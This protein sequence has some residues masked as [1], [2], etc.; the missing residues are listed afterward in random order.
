MNTSFGKL[1]GHSNIQ[2]YAKNE[3]IWGNY[4]LKL[5]IS[6]AIWLESHEPS[7]SIAHFEKTFLIYLH[8]SKFVGLY[9][10]QDINQDAT[11]RFYIFLI[12]LNCLSTDFKMRSKRGRGAWPVI[13]RCGIL[14]NSLQIS[15][16][17]STCALGNDFLKK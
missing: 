11:R 6:L 4:H 13:A 1:V 2:T 15:D 10:Y 12:F 5:A 7:Y 14:Q 3:I 9:G 8:Y 17:M 16:E